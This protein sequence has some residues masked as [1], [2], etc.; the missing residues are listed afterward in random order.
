LKEELTTQGCEE[1]ELV[2]TNLVQ[3]DSKS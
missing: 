3:S 1:M 2:N